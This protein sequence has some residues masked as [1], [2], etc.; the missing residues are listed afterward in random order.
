[1]SLEDQSYPDLREVASAWPFLDSDVR[2]M[3]LGV[4]RA[5][6]KPAPMDGR[7]KIIVSR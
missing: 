4:V 7:G 5:T 1:L 2:K 3:I 6:R